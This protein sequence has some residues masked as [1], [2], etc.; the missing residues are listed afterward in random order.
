MLQL[1]IL[2]GILQIGLV[3]TLTSV[4]LLVL[5]YYLGFR[6]FLRRETLNSLDTKTYEITL[7]ELEVT[8]FQSRLPS[9]QISNDTEKPA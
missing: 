5:F 3:V 7:T 9:R 2:W 8:Q 6:G 1:E 4:G